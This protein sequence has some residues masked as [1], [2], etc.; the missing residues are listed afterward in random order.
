VLFNKS[1]LS[2]LINQCGLEMAW[3]SY[4]QGAS[5]WTVSILGMPAQKRI[6]SGDAERPIY[7]HPLW[8]PIATLASAFD[9]ARLPFSKTAQMFCLLKH[10]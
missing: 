7:E 1:N 2:Q 5:Q 6:I 9:I 3:F 10:L 4:T 8:V